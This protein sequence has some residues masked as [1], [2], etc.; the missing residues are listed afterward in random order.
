MAVATKAAA[1]VALARLLL[2]AAGPAI[3]E[4]QPVIAVLAVASI[5]VGNAGAIGQDSLKRLLGY[6]GIAQAGYMLAGVVVASEAGLAA[7]VF[8]LAI[9]VFMN[10]AAF[11]V[12]VVRERETAHG[13]RI[14]SVEGLGAERPWLAWPL[15]LA[16]LGLAGL[17]G[18][19][20]F[21]GKLFLIE[22]AVDGNYT[23]LGV[24]IVVGSMVSLA[25]YLRVVAAIW[26]KP[27]PAP[28]IAGASPQAEE[29]F[30]LGRNDPGPAEP[31]SGPFRCL[32]VTAVAVICGAAIVAAGVA[33]DPVTDWAREAAESLAVFT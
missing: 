31:G 2:E 25:Y 17:P 4:W 32:A 13:D 6:S 24:A 30:R 10:V 18:T 1:F 8:Y 23:W 16:M 27:A 19:A 26:M 12:I 20:G 28:V 14:E 29:E 33:P 21:V 5:V 7:L 11:T 22:A 9:Y 15:T 3:D